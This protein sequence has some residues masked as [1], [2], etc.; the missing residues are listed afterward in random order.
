VV[1][2]ETQIYKC[3][4]VGGFWLVLVLGLP[5]A[6]DP[7]EKKKKFRIVCMEVAVGY[8]VDVRY[9]WQGIYARI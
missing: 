6:L 8:H 9:A 3:C 2:D 5:L 4:Y 1:E 7:A